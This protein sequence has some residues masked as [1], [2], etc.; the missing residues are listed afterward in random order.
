MTKLSRVHVPI[1]PAA[2]RSVTVK[3]RMAGASVLISPAVI[4]L[5]IFVSLE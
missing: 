3:K 2:G 1:Q 5:V 4:T